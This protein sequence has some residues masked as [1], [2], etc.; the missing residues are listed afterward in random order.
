MKNRTQ[1]KQGRIR[2]TESDTRERRP[3]SVYAGLQDD[4]GRGE[5]LIVELRD[6]TT[7]PYTARFEVG[8]GETLLE[9]GR[10]VSQATTTDRTTFG[11]LFGCL[12][13]FFLTLPPACSRGLFTTKKM[14]KINLLTGHL[15]SGGRRIPLTKGEFAIVDDSDFSRVNAFSWYALGRG[16]YVYAYRC[17]PREKGEKGSKRRPM[18]REVL[19]LPPGNVPEVDHIDHQTLRNVR[20]NLRIVT[21]Q[22]NQGNRKDQSQFGPGVTKRNGKYLARSWVEGKW[23]YLGAFGTPEEARQ[24]RDHV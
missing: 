22:Q 16:D 14:T 3:R 9:S 10:V 17:L 7:T 15:G 19:G 5:V 23:A 13:L 20:S 18:H 1:N 11:L 6:Q 4:S 12:V 21:H 24:A 8:L 2:L